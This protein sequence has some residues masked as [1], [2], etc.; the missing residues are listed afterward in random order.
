[1]LC[2]R[3]G[4][5]IEWRRVSTGKMIL[6]DVPGIPIFPGEGKELFYMDGGSIVRGRRAT[7]K[8]KNSSIG[9]TSHFVTCPGLKNMMPF[10]GAW[11]VINKEKSGEQ[12]EKI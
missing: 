2:K 12:N 5:K 6:V 1:M 3:C 8:T 4:A 9:Y 7:G 11:D 10:G